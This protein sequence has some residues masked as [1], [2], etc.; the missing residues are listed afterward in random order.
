MVAPPIGTPLNIPE[1][2][3]QGGLPSEQEFIQQQEVPR[4]PTFP[5]AQEPPHD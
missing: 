3:F 4:V 5:P 2:R 1:T